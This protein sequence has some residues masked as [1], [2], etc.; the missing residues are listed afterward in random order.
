MGSCRCIAECLYY[1][2]V[3]RVLFQ[4]IG[5]HV[6]KWHSLAVFYEL[7]EGLCMFKGGEPFCVMKI[8]MRVGDARFFIF[9][10]VLFLLDQ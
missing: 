5:V 4:D 1:C 10:C 7:L 9:M 8:N 3:K 2:T 6:K